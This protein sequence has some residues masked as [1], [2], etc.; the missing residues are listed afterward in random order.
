MRVFQWLRVLFGDKSSPDLAGYAI[1]YLASNHNINYPLGTE[2]LENGTYVDDIGYSVESREDANKI[3]NEIDEILKH[4][5]FSV[6]YW[7][8]NSS[9]VDKSPN[10]DIVGV[11]GHLWDKRNELIRVKF[12]DLS[13][14]KTSFTKRNLMGIV[15]RLW[16]PFGYLIHVTI[17]YRIHLQKI[18]QEGYS[19]DEQINEEHF[20]IWRENIHEI[21][22]LEKFQLNRCLKPKNIVGLPQLH[23]FSDGG[24][25]AY[26]TCVFIYWPTSTGICTRLVAAKAF[27]AP[28]KH[29]TTPRLKLMGAV[30]MGRLIAEIGKAL[31]Y[32]F[33]FKRF[34][35]DSTVVIYW[36]K[37]TSRQY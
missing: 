19:W 6:K 25:D 26:G 1:R 36:L 33:E 3:A 11:L 20:E 30:V 27:V 23:G 2:I 29:K 31:S 24:N 9:A 5:K 7:N 37:S 8:T 12:K 17:K 34:W 15:A 4:G 22:K 21:Q 16:D 28:L 13:I 35:V 14:N 32:Q 10:E 18:W